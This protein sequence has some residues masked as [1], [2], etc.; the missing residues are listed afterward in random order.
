[1]EAP[2]SPAPDLQSGASA[3][4]GE[5]APAGPPGR[6]W[7]R[8]FILLWLGQTIS[9]LGNPA[10]NIGAML[11]MKEA[12]GSA[13]LMGLLMTASMVPVLLL[14]PFGGTFA[15]RHSRV[16]IMIWC[17]LISGIAL[18]VFAA[19]LWLW[20]NDTALIIPLLFAVAVTEGVVRAFFMPAVSAII[21]D[22]VPG[23][24]LPAANSLNQLSIQASLF[25]G[26]AVGGILYKAFGP[27]LLFCIDGVSYLVAAVCTL[28]IPRDARAAPPAA[29]V[30]AADAAGTAD[31]HPLRRFL[32]ETAEGFRYVWAQKGQR[33]FL[34]SV[35][36]VNFLA[37]PGT[38]LFPFYVSD[39]LHV[40][41][42][43]YGYLTA[44]ISVG[45]VVG[46][47]GAGALRLSGPG[48]AQGILT[49]L[50]LYPVV[51]GSLALWRHPIPALVAV[52]LG[53]LTVGFINIYLIT[54]VQA[55]TPADLRGRVLAFLGLLTGGL[56]PIGMA[57][58]GVI[59]DLTDKNVPLVMAVSAVLAMLTVTL[60][61]FRRQ[62]R[63][64]LAS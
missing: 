59:G 9:Q 41:Q 28:F 20:P 63:E 1:M 48:R 18:A 11:W 35:S 10:F 5:A 23:D 16:R 38:V 49:A 53:G 44:G 15:D 57:L 64:Y 43:W 39:Y 14:S 61:C 50:V 21:P 56:M 24:Q 6:L 30:G 37:M 31:A 62:C 29:T 52:V 8:S 51:F 55:S 36:I 25:S 22:L 54:M 42:E 34:L 12:T 19:A 17:D 4:E 45:V 60:L 32:A 58:G 3:L 26:Q 46:F 47:L 33:D 7:N 2:V 40:G 27:A 13:S